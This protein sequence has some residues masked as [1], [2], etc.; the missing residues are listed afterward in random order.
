M[1]RGRG[2]S[3]G[4]TFFAVSFFD[5]RFKTNM[6]LSKIQYTALLLTFKFV[7]IRIENL[8]MS[9]KLVQTLC[10]WELKLHF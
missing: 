1:K 10:L 6:L 5:G 8:S 9:F 2:R 7:Q 3:V 4:R